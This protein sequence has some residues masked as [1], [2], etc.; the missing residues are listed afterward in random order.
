MSAYKIRS[1]STQA[2]ADTKN[3]VSSLEE[4]A[5]LVSPCLNN[6]LGH[7]REIVVTR[8]PGR[9]DVMGGIA[10]YSG[11]L[12]LQMPIAAA[13]HVA[14]QPNNTKSVRI[15]SLSW[16]A[17]NRLR[18][19]QLS[20]DDLKSSQEPIEYRAARELFAPHSDNHWAAYVAGA[21]LV[22]MREKDISIPE[23]ADILISSSV[24]E[25]KGVSSSA[26]LEVATLN[27]LT[28]SLQ[29]Q[30]APQQIALLCQK[31]ENEVAGAACGVMD[32][33]TAECGE[34]DR[35]LELL[36]QPCELQGTLAIPEELEFWGIDSGKRH[37]VGG[38]DYTTV[39]TAAFMGYR[40][41]A[42]IKGLNLDSN[43]DQVSVLDPHWHG[44]LANIT[45]QEFEQDLAHKLPKQISGKEFLDHWQGITDSVTRVNPDTIY[46]VLQATRHPVLENDR[47]RKFAD[48]LKHWNGL[49]Q[50]VRLGQLMFESHQSYSSCGLGSPETDVIVNLVKSAINDRLYG[51][52]ITGG[53]C[54]G[55]VA[56]LGQRNN[57]K[58][59]ERVQYDYQQ[60]TGIAASIISGSSPGAHV[61]QHL[62][63]YPANSIL[64]K[65]ETA[66]EPK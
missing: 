60:H 8:A 11:S 12:V 38:S 28:T 41:I 10:D 26:A 48:I 15:A 6:F 4:I 63:L 7:Q 31:V 53:G 62:T 52:R 47:V 56:V 30:L 17:N 51:A 19:C 57:R 18:T 46:P 37:V 59:I 42:G 35:L 27:A 43:D 55:T 29:L 32:Q 54:G 36:C 22:L 39:R 33:M 5:E 25:G 16:P 23:G 3:F 65:T 13:T 50:A 20:I 45:P 9:L 2:F 49:E 21:Y 24:P 61:F 66:N 14:L 64:L 1:G 34:A 40:M 58:A 44:Y